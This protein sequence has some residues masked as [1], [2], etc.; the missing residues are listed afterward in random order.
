MDSGQL[1]GIAGSNNTRG[2]VI[3]FAG[4]KPE[5]IQMFVR[6]I[7]SD[8]HDNAFVFFTKS[9]KT[10]DPGGTVIWNRSIYS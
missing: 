2:A 4:L 8:A 6:T 7:V 10:V 3:K 9:R 5:K 1:L